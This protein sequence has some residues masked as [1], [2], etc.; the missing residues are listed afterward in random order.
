M[1]L[2]R[3]GQP[4]LVWMNLDYSPI[5]DEGG[6][7]AGVLAVVVDCTGKVRAERRADGERQR[8]Q[9]MFEQAPGFM[10]MM[11][12][13]DH[14]FDFVN[15]A[16]Q[17]LIGHRQV[18]G[19]PVRQALP[20]IAGQGFIEL[21]DQVYG[22]GEAF[23]GTG[24]RAQLQRL[25]HGAVEDRFVD[26]VYQPV[27]D[28]SGAV[29]G[30]FVQGTDATER[31]LAQ[32]SL[33]A[34]E[35]QFRAFSEVMPDQVWAADPAGLLD[36][37]NPRV[38]AYSGEGPGG[39]HGHG[40]VRMVHP[41]DLPDAQARWAT[42]LATG[43]TY[44]TEFR[45]RRADGSYRW[46]I[47][48]A[49][50]IRDA[51]GAIERWV[52]TNTDIEDQKAA[53]QALRDLNHTLEQ[54]VAE[55]TADRDRMWRLSTDVMLVASLAGRIVSVNP[56]WLSLLGWEERELKGRMF[57]DLVHPDDQAATLAEVGRLAEGATTFRF[58]NRYVRKDGSY[59]LLSW[60]AVPDDAFIHAVGRDVTADREA[61]DTLRRTEAALHQAQ[62]MET[63]GQLT[64]GVAHDFNNL[65]Q[66]ISG[67]LQLLGREV[68]GNERAERQVI[69]ALAGTQ[70]GAKLASQLLAFARRQPLEPRVLQIGRL[71]AGMGEMLRRTLGESV[72]L[73]TVG[74]GGLWNTL[75]D[76]AQLENVILNLAINARDAMNGVGRLTLEVGNAHLD[77]SYA[78]ANPDVRP[79]Q[80]VMLAI[81]D[82]G[83]GMT[84]EV[85][86]R[87]F[88]PFFTTKPEGK[89]TGL[90]LSMV[91][92]FAKQSGGHVN[93]Y[94]EPG[95]GTSVKLYLPRSLEMEDVAAPMASLPAVGGSETVLV[96][97][98]DDE[99][100]STVVEMLSDL[101]YR[102]LTARDAAG[103]LAILE[104]GVAVDVLFTDVVMP[105]NLRSPEL[106][107][108]ARALLPGI[109]VLFT[110]GYTQNAIVHGGRLDAGVE[111]LGKPYTVEALA[112]KLRHVI[113]NQG[114][115]QLAGAPGIAAAPNAAPRQTLPTPLRILFVEDDDL[116][117]S[118][119]AEVLADLGHVV[120]C[121]A[122]GTA[123][124]ALL[125]PGAFDL[126]MTD[127]GLP[128]MRGEALAAA[129][130]TRDAGIAILVASGN[131]MPAGSLPP[132]TLAVV[133]PYDIET[134]VRTLAQVEPRSPDSRGAPV[135]G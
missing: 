14:V 133:K 86:A 76:P 75:A 10:A 12:G 121:A 115:R 29:V 42:A 13:P 39:L 96:A 22:S 107:R 26:L 67:N 21:L 49:L 30:I 90:G 95:H 80:Y 73:E 103:A 51:Q 40:W 57:L 70:R 92:G 23:S 72:E 68:T 43:Q 3:R 64:G 123:A 117:R 46:H 31:E 120:E 11:S 102:V 38:Y 17:Q 59:C 130:R 106:A 131:A 66:V 109:A 125:Q 65:L 126:L 15:P 56:A 111:L 53:A 112:R 35:E 44:E 81:S 63:V 58:E 36:W 19:L 8:L 79:G 45:L 104:S 82:T 101:G 71:V 94:S 41:Q 18:I 60:T 9:Q 122:D 116:V 69:N 77:D 7:V 135:Q 124:L 47:A 33:R 84:P 127:M 48:R 25:P 108:R 50:P 98:D 32:Q 129:A 27:R 132:G 89:G 110:S 128:D 99:V 74:G 16:Y 83:Q 52:G 4:E 88:E 93:I 37:F 20:E 61:A 62:K 119:T 6:T 113:G 24:L 1:S 34:S 118:S 114:Q 28:D 134:L 100:R 85:V 97:E 91:Y 5:L 78:Q 2:T 105:G 54:Q 87:A 55:R